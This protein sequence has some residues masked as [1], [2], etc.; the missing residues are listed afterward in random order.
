MACL[1]M[2]NLSLSTTCLCSS[3]RML[4][5]RP[6]Q[7]TNGVRLPTSLS[8]V[9]L[10][11]LAVL[12]KSP[13]LSPPTPQRTLLPPKKC[14]R[15]TTSHSLTSPWQVCIWVHFLSMFASVWF[16]VSYFVMSYSF[17]HVSTD[18]TK[19]GGLSMLL[20]AGE[21]ALTAREVWFMIMAF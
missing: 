16:S 4:L 12:V 14:P 15:L 13:G 17:H 1:Y 2:S 6:T 21:H 9:H 3:I 19:M 7:G 5:W 20:L 8:R 18:P 11:Q 10:K